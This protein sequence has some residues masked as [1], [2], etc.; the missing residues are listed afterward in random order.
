MKRVVKIGV[1]CNAYPLFVALH[2]LFA[3]WSRLSQALYTIMP[4]FIFI[5]L[6][7]IWKKDS[8]I[9]LVPLE[10]T[11]VSYLIFMMLVICFY[12][13]LCI[14]SKSGWVA[15]H[16]YQMAAFIVS[17]LGFYIVNYY[18]AIR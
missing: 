15:N 9:Q 3:D 18:N 13:T 6:F 8:Q 4:L 17:T 7:M 16:N 2:L 10:K 11:F 5:S 14:F 12:Y 1:L